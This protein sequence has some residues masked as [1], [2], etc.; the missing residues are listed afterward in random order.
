MQAR[1]GGRGPGGQGVLRSA[2]VGL[3]GGGNS[4]VAPRLAGGP[5]HGVIAV[6]PFLEQRIVVVALGVEAGAAVLADDDIAA[7]GEEPDGM[8]LVIGVAILA[9]RPP[10]DQRREA[11]RRVGAVD[12]GGQTRA[13]AHRP[14]LRCARG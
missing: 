11:A 5:L 12:V 10:R 2:E 14:P 13:V 9:V 7:L 8:L 3:A 4:P 1:C 6:L